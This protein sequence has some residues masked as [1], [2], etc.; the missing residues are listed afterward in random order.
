M[1]TKQ[2]QFLVPFLD[3]N[4]AQNA[5]KFL[6]MFWPVTLGPVPDARG[7]FLKDVP[8]E[9]T[10][11]DYANLKFLAKTGPPKGPQKVPKWELKIQQFLDRFLD[12]F[13]CPFRVQGR[14]R[15]TGGPNHP[16]RPPV[17]IY[18]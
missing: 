6:T 12:R 4:M 9:I 14:V 18:K 13:L 11:L 5:I 2:Q 7:W 17:L 15:S 3:P 8:C 1:I 10:I 16:P